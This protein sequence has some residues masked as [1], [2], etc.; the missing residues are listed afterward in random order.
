MRQVKSKIIYNIY[1]KITMKK[2][3]HNNI[4]NINGG[5]AASAFCAGLAVGRIGIAAFNAAVAVGVISATAL[6]TGGTAVIA[7]AAV[8]AVYGLGNQLSWWN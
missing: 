5:G 4:E 1:I 8:C 3:S 7:I 6:A 2:L